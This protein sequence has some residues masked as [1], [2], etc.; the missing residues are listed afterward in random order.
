MKGFLAILLL[1][2]G[3][4]LAVDSVIPAKALSQS[5]IERVQAATNQL[6]NY[7]PT[8]STIADHIGK[9]S[10]VSSVAAS[11][12]AMI[13]KSTSAGTIPSNAQVTTTEVLPGSIGTGT[14]GTTW[15]ST[16]SI[17]SV[18]VQQTYLPKVKCIDDKDDDD[19]D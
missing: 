5:D 1:A 13:A 10:S 2:F 15:M 7:V 11:I 19:K 8:A 3:I 18:P 6:C 16:T 14:S 12:C 17:V 4:T 9:Y